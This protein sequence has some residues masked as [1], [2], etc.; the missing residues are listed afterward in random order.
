MDFSEKLQ[1]LRKQ[2]QMTQEQLAE[3]LYVSRTAI[4]K[5]ESGKGYPNIESLKSIS[6]LFSVS[7]D[8]LLSGEELIV[9]AE[10]EN[11]KNINRLLNFIYGVLD[12]LCLSFIFLPLYGQKEVDFIQSVSL[13][14]YHDASLVIRTI[15][16][17]LLVALF[18][19]GII[20]LLMRH[21]NDEKGLKKV[22]LISIF[23]HGSAVIFFAISLQ[24]YVNVM[25][26]M[27][28]IIKIYLLIKYKNS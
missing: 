25:L 15:Y 28:F 7:I 3:C 22:K 9:L 6:K 18:V 4:S 17:T 1:Q 21:F 19:F 14:A 12:L 23:I 2:K 24:P 26:F 11:G 5:W 10:N 16:F 20:E 8:E 27:L 13:L